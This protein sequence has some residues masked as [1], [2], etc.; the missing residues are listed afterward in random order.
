MGQGESV[1]LK[2]LLLIEM[3]LSFRTSPFIG[4][5]SN[6]NVFNNNKNDSFFFVSIETLYRIIGFLLK[7]PILS[8]IDVLEMFNLA[9]KISKKHSVLKYCLKFLFYVMMGVS[10][11]SLC[12]LKV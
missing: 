5:Y 12:L 7:T 1:T 2:Y 10:K 11:D 8:G 4:Y 9:G 6:W 3:S